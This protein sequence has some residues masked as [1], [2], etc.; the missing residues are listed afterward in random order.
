MSLDVASQQ[1]FLQPLRFDDR[2]AAG[3]WAPPQLQKV[4][5]SYPRGDGS[6]AA[7]ASGTTPQPETDLQLAM[8]ANDVYAADNPQ[9]EAAL[10]EAGWTRLEPSADGTSL[11][12]AQGNEI[13]IDP[14]LLSTAEGFDAAIY[15][16]AQGEYVV[17]YRGTDDWS[18]AP[19]GDAD[20]NGL[21]GLGF[22]TGQYKDAVA[23]GEAALRAFG[24]GNVVF[25]GHSL[26][27]GLASAAALATGTTGVTFNAAGLSDQTLESL[28]FNPNAVR[29]EAADSGQLRR[30]IVNG[31]PLNGAQQDLPILPI[32]GMS[33]PNAVGH[34]LR[35]DPPAGM[36]GP[37]DL[38]AL[39]GGGGDNASYVD[40]LQQN[41]AYAP[42]SRPS[43]SEQAGGLV[44]KGLDGLGDLANR[45]F[46][47]TG[48]PAIGWAADTLL[49]AGGDLL[50]TT[51]G[52]GGNILRDGVER[53]GEYSLNQLGSVIRQGENVVG[54]LWSNGSEMIDGF[55]D[56]GN[57]AFADG[58]LVEGSLE[59][60][61]DV[62]DFAVDSVGDLADGALGLVGDTTQNLANA[63]GGL[64]RD[65]GDATGLDAPLDAVA[66]FVEGAGK[67]VSDVADTVGGAVDTVTDV[68]GDGVEVVA[69]VVGDFGQAVTDGA[70]WV[71]DKLNPL[72]WF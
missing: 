10:A 63:G 20:D 25:T 48:D 44:N 53:V 36:G 23:L 29:Q 62:L 64:L 61:G 27:G 40:A 32:L 16:N 34:E 60:V 47:A 31:D 13:P 42:A 50:D 69:D 66:G 1:S 7:D 70:Q 65:I 9:T 5:D 22:E 11:V 52:V 68:L 56:A 43:L 59:V 71:S 18:L 14:A 28:G 45:F 54:D 19:S 41:T 24:E 49:D 46:T 72:K 30:Y 8:M 55:T 4:A 3:L 39:H 2:L 6:F 12:D 26:G 57:G 37:G 51:I 38:V 15:Q 58:K 67:V 33:P 21:Q 35:I 17:A